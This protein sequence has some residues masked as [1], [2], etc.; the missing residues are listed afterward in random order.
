MKTNKNNYILETKFAT[1]A[2]KTFEYKREIESAFNKLKFPFVVIRI[3]SKWPKFI[4]YDISTT[5]GN[6]F[7]AGQFLASAIRKNFY[8][9]FELA[10]I[11]RWLSTPKNRLGK[12]R[13]STII[14]LLGHYTEDNLWLRYLTLFDRHCKIDYSLPANPDT[15]WMKCLEYGYRQQCCSHT[16]RFG[17]CVADHQIKNHPCSEC[18]G[19]TRCT[20]ILI[21]CY[22][23]KA[24]HKATDSLA[25][26]YIFISLSTV[27][28]VS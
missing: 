10:Q 11:P 26:L 16:G 12:T 15:Q 7:K 5:I 8:N 6:A 4:I 2:T 21:R 9:T 14:A 18:V 28:R 23:C 19:R 20:H 24:P 27:P 1:S 22:Y 17:Q 3:N 25:R 13:S